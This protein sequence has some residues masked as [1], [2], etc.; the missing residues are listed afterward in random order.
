MLFDYIPTE[1]QDVDILTKDFQRENSSYMEAGSRH[2]IIPCL[3]RGSVE[4]AARKI[5]V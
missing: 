3:L 4:N 5:S 2:L 1:E